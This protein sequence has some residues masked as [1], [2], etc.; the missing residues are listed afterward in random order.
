MAEVRNWDFHGLR[1]SVI[2]FVLCMNLSDEYLKVK[3]PKA[4]QYIIDTTPV[5]ILELFMD[6]SCLTASK[7]ADM[8]EV[9]RVVSGFMDWSRFKLKSSK[10]RAPVYDKGKVM[11]WVVEGS[12]EVTEKLI[13][14]DV[15]PK[16]KC[17]RKANQ[18]SRKMD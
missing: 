5:P 10:S 6:D 14:G 2:I 16:S 9:L 13:D 7:R 17:L 3:I 1:E 15:I 4:I 18:V 12:E 8:Q 11:E